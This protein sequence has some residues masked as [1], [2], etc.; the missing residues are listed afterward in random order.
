MSKSASPEK[1]GVSQL[2]RAHPEP[3]QP[4]DRPGNRAQRRQK[5]PRDHR[6]TL[7]G[8]SETAEESLSTGEA[9]S[10]PGGAL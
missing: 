4:A 3:P 8:G 7:A 9:L 6:R 1:S 2:S 5:D 10:E